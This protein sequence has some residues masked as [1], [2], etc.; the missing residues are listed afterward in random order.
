ME[1]GNAH[2]DEATVTASWVKTVGLEETSKTSISCIPHFT[3]VIKSEFL[4]FKKSHRANMT[5]NGECHQDSVTRDDRNRCGLC[6]F[7]E[8]DSLS[9]ATLTTADSGL[10]EL[11]SF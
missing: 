9:S 2:A 6:D 1:N 4:L 10:P 5:I 11:L 3:R 7:S 8:A